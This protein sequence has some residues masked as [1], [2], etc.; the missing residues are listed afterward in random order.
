MHMPIPIRGVLSVPFWV[1]G[2]RQSRMHPNLCTICET[3]F[4][5]VQRKKQIST[6]TTV[7]FADLR[8]Y[9][10]ATQSSDAGQVSDMLNMFYDQCASAV[11]EY[12][13]I[14]NK[15][16]GDAVLAIFNFP[17]RQKDHA[18]Q[19]VLAGKEIQRRCAEKKL[20]LKDEEGKDCL[21]GIGIGIH[22]GDTSVG[23]FGHTAKDFTFI[24]SVVN[25]AS[26]VQAV[27]NMGDVVV[28]EQVFRHVSDLFPQSEAQ[29]HQVKGIDY[30]IIAHRV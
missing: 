17:I 10:G 16:I 13:G 15:F 5:R 8:G 6:D 18:R 11:W 14:V 4:K 9:T 7:L 23:Q 25:I 26:R 12:D 24:G 21:M 30:P 19:A 28:T 22:T 2:I 20:M 29:T 3:M 27:A 1:A